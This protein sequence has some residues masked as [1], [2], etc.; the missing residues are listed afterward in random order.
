MASKP[1]IESQEF[2]TNPVQSF[3]MPLS[4][5]LNRSDFQDSFDTIDAFNY[6]EIVDLEAFMN[7]PVLVEIDTTTEKNAEQTVQ[8]SVNG[9]NQFLFRGKPHWIK[10]KYLEV[11]ARCKPETITTPEYTNG[12]GDKATRIDKHPGHKYPFRVHKD[13]NPKGY[14]WLQQIIA[15][16]T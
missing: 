1:P 13:P 10:R 8:L 15:E 2:K 3:E 14:S 4:G 7:E 6:K 11:L 5:G 9:V 12:N 16:P